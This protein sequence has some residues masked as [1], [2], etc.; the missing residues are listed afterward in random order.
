MAGNWKGTFEKWELAVGDLCV[1]VG[2]EKYSSL[3]R[4]TVY[5]VVSKV[6]DQTAS[7]S[8]NTYGYRV[9]FDFENPTGSST[10]VIQG[11]GTRGMRKISLLDLATLRLHLDAFIKDFARYR[12]MEDEHASH[13]CTDSTDEAET[14]HD[15]PALA[16]AGQHD[17]HG[18]PATRAPKASQEG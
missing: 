8:N 5:Q 12:G 7:Y 13:R 17:D 18:A 15:R 2:D 1:F 6:A 4:R 16:E 9:A 14:G 10:D 3:H 11:L